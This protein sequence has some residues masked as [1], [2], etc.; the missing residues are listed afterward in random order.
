MNNKK[1]ELNAGTGM[2]L[3]VLVGTIVALIVSTATG[4]NFVWSWAIPAGL[5]GGLAIGAGAA[6][7]SADRHEDLK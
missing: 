5:A 3:G 6:K 1:L 4:D 7:K 2:T